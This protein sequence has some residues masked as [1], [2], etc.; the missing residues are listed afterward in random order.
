MSG[1]QDFENKTWIL[2]M[3]YKILL[4]RALACDSVP[5]GFPFLNNIVALFSL[6]W[7][8]QIFGPTL[9]W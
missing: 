8:P 6:F 1:I 2:L 4:R 9:I 3:M 5:L 7:R